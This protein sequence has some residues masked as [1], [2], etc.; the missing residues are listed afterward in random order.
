MF[1]IVTCSVLSAYFGMTTSWKRS[2][3][4]LSWCI[5]GHT[6]LRAHVGGARRE[7]GARKERGSG[8]NTYGVNDRFSGVCAGMLAE[9][10]RLQT[11]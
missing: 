4:H 2:H 8:K 6:Y 7:R 9:P 1:E 5:A 3:D 10:I 11:E